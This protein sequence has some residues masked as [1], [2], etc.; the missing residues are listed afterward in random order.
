MKKAPARESDKQQMQAPN[1][2]EIKKRRSKMESNDS[3]GALCNRN[4]AEDWRKQEPCL[5]KYAKPVPVN[6]S[7]LLNVFNAKD[8][9]ES[10]AHR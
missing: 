10:T 7:V 9:Q 5:C 6:Q 4:G 8:E 1:M 3:G 2:G